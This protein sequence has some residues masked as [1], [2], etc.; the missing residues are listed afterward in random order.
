M[1]LYWKLTKGW[2]IGKDM[3][4]W[5]L[6]YVIVD[7]STN[8]RCQFVI[9]IHSITLSTRRMLRLLRS[10][11]NSYIAHGQSWY[12]GYWLSKIA[13]RATL[14]QA[15]Y[16]RE[17]SARFLIVS[18]MPVTQFREPYCRKAIQSKEGCRGCVTIEWLLSSTILRSYASTRDEIELQSP[19]CTIWGDS[20]REEGE[21]SADQ[22]RIELS[23]RH[24]TS[25]KSAPAEAPFDRSK[26]LVESRETS[27]HLRY[28]LITSRKNSWC[29]L[30]SE[31]ISFQTRNLAQ[32]RISLN[33]LVSRQSGIQS[34][35]G[36]VWS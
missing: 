34:R 1:C 18:C 20:R 26:G 16:S 23:D 3:S 32:P 35:H 7:S 14:Y 15:I 10:I 13:S 36:N 30:Y 25:I 2:R 28:D 24:C 21:A 31:V 4:W 9:A 12:L 11:A 17:R 19:S 22:Q 27:F 5:E 33:L 29:N 6:A 8:L